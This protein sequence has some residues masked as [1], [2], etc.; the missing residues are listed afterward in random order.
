MRTFNL[1]LV[2]SVDFLHFGRLGGSPAIVPPLNR[3]ARSE[4]QS[5]MAT[6]VWSI[7]MYNPGGGFLKGE[8]GFG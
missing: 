8:G 6:R 1:I 7:K 3:R 4:R 5:T 2:S